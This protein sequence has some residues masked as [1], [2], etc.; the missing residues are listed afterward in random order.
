MRGDILLVRMDKNSEPQPFTLVEW[1]QFVDAGGNVPA[2]D[3]AQSGDKRAERG[4]EDGGG[5]GESEQKDGTS[6]TGGLQKKQRNT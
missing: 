4:A 1:Q 6:S 2:T 3:S 5:A